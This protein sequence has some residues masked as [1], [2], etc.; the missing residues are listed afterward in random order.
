MS[1]AEK[2]RAFYG[3]LGGV[4]LSGGEPFAQKER[5]VALL[6][7]C[8]ERGL[9]TAVETC[10]YAE[11]DILRAAVPFTDLFLFD[12]KDT[13]PLRH[14]QYTGVANGLILNNLRVISEM[15]ARIRLRCILVNGI[16]TN[17]THCAK[18]A[19]LA[20]QVKHLEGVEWIPYHAYGGTKAT[21]LGG[22]DNGQK[23]WIPTV[24]EL[25][26]AKEALQ[27]HGACVL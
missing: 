3:E 11:T 19:E 22:S 15:G 21:F 5:T 7:A 4:T 16:N 25:Q 13:D 17:E 6:R 26:R 20:Q 10:G 2:D 1:V 9:S 18:I 27:A 24:E 12:I 8:K 14:Q 23:K